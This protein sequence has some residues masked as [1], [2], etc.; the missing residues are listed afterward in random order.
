MTA[1]VHGQILHSPHRLRWLRCGVWTALPL[2][3][4]MVLGQFLLYPGMHGYRY[5]LHHGLINETIRKPYLTRA[6][7]PMTIRT[8]LDA[9]PAFWHVR[10]QQIVETLPILGQWFAD[11]EWQTDFALGYLF[12]VIAMTGALTGFVVSVR[13]LFRSMYVVP[14]HVTDIVMIVAVAGLP[15]FLRYTTY[16][17]DLFTVWFF[18]WAIAALA[19]RRWWHYLLVFT[20]ATWNKE[21]SI[22]LLL[23]FFLLFWKHV[24]QTAPRKFWSLVIAQGILYMLVR[25]ALF[26]HYRNASGPIMEFHLFD[27][28]FSFLQQTDLVHAVIAWG[29]TAMMLFGIGLLLFLFWKEK[30]PLLCTALFMVLPLIVLASISGFIDEFRAYFEIYPVVAL[31]SLHT[32][33]RLAGLSL[34]QSARAR[35]L[36]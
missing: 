13:N 28:T 31:L 18:T 14:P 10:A 4:L 16:L 29:G 11:L 17:Y 27:H 33:L 21:T 35:V 8:T 30:P 15:L 20:L 7:V 6:L 25:G 26:W 32:V 3:M 5:D 34:R 36:L 9:L 19:Q 23:L 24:R 12:V 2:V 1:A 22:L